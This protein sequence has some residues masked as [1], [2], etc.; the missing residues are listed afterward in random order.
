MTRLPSP[1]DRSK[2][3]PLSGVTDDEILRSLDRLQSADADIGTSRNFRPRYYA[4]RDVI[5]LINTCQSS[6]IEKNALY[7]GSSFP[8][9]K[10]IEQDL[11]SFT[12]DL[13]NGP[14]GCTGTVTTGGSESNF[15]AVKAARDAFFARE[16]RPAAPEVVLAHTAHPSLEKAARML[17]VTVRRARSSI[18]YRADVGAM[19]ALVNSRTALIVG[20]APPAAYATVDPIGELGAIAARHEL[21]FHVDGCLGGFF[22][23]FAEQLGENLPVFDFRDDNVTSMSADLHKFGYAPKGV[24]CLLV[25]SA[26]LAEHLQFEFD[27][28]PFGL[29][30]TKALAGSKPAGPMVAAWAVIQK[31]GRSG[32]LELA[33]H[34]LRLRK[35]LEAGVR[36]IADL[37]VIGTPAA[38][39]LFVASDTLDILAVDEILEAQG[40]LTDRAT[41]PDSIQVWLNTSHD[42]AAIDTLLD[43][44]AEA[45]DRIERSG[46]RAA[47]RDAVY[48]R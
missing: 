1:D 31:L 37:Y 27:D 38:G 43:A 23:P 47:R 3:F 30:R 40:F 13:L 2:R 44:L 19:E 21:W 11:V 46:I 45:A 34:I 25:R 39:H 9:L 14:D 41:Q 24:S 35:H 33:D 36:Q 7:A 5:D 20:S 26:A 22:L 17:G 8:S 28:W 48:T 16:S 10:A 15:M 6:A 42:S 32:F 4:G 29:Y 18:D 12:V